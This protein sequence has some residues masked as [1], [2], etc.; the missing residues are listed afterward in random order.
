MRI[1]TLKLW[2]VRIAAI[3]IVL[4]LVLAGFVA[5]LYN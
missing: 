1:K 2:A 4:V 5:M 3:A